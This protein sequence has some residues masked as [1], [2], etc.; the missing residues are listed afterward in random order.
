MQ[1]RLKTA[2]FLLERDFGKQGCIYRCERLVDI[3]KRLNCVLK[4]QWSHA[5]R[6]A[7]YRH[8]LVGH[9]GFTRARRERR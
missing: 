6:A 9:L 4:F 8:A 3:S 7:I 1:S 5:A 2:S